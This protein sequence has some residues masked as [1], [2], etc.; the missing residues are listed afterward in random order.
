LRDCWLLGLM[1]FALFPAPGPGHPRPGTASRAVVGGVRDDGSAGVV[2]LN[3]TGGGM[4]SAVVAGPRLV[5]TAAHCVAGRLPADLEL[6][7]GVDAGAPDVRVAIEAIEL[8]PGATGTAEDYPGGV[9]VAA[10]RPAAEVTAP[11]LTLDL[12]GVEPGAMVT[13]I[14]YGAS[15]GAGGGAGGCA[16]GGGSGAPVR[17]HGSDGRTPATRLAPHAV[18]LRALQGGHWGQA[19]PDCPRPD[20]SCH[21]GEAG[22][23]TIAPG[24]MAR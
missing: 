23:C 11:A 1:L 12:S 5:L 7:L 17:A 4:C 14:G 2:A 15:D 21:A 13:L 19:C 24:R 8:A 18:W 9:D 10:L 3:V 16:G 20:D 22:G 6:L